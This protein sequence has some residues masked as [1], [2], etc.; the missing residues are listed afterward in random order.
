VCY[1][2]PEHFFYFLEV[3]YNLE[4]GLLLNF[5]E[6]SLNSSDSQTESMYHH[7]PKNQKNHSSDQ[8][9]A[10]TSGW[11]SLTASYTVKQAGYAYMYVSNEQQVLM[12]VYFDDVT[13]TFTPSAVVQQEDFYPFGLTFN[14]YTRQNTVAQ[15]FLYNG[16][17]LQNDLS[18]D[19]L[20]YGAR[21]YDPAIGRW[22]H[23]TYSFSYYSYSPYAYVTN[24]PVNNV[25]VDMF[26]VH[27]HRDI[28]RNALR[29]AKLGTSGFGNLILGNTIIAD[30]PVPAGGMFRRWHFDGKDAKGIFDTYKG[31][32]ESLD[33]MHEMNSTRLGRLLHTVQDFYAHSNY[34]ELFIEHYSKKNGTTPSSKD[35]PTLEE[36]ISS[37][38]F[39][40][41]YEYL[42]ENLQTGNFLWNNDSKTTHK[43]LNKDKPDPSRT[44]ANGEQLHAFALRAA[45][46][47]TQDILEM[48]M[49]QWSSS[50]GQSN[51]SRS[52]HLKKMASIFH[53]HHFWG[54]Q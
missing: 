43:A 16:K 52:T 22:A 44:A 37:P 38:A 34:V 46:E 31:I 42:Q 28:T 12:D 18:L 35:I 54:P 10:S 49:S 40:D 24:D 50:S 25:D 47:H 53:P 7:N 21:Q 6:Q 5:G 20:D 9:L 17:E 30:W 26:K 13:M 32:K 45:T 3:T 19:W 33:D 41:F 11:G 23:Y 48:F 39:D 51:S 14:S 8:Q 29:S 1:F 4:I 36:A 2:I 15:N 27:I